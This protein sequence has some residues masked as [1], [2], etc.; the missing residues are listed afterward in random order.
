MI[1]CKS[2][3]IIYISIYIL[4]KTI[5]FVLQLLHKQYSFN[6]HE[7]GVYYVIHKLK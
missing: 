1:L 5:L 7:Y 2:T 6:L 3:T 4:K